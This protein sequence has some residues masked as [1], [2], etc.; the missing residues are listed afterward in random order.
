MTI[1]ILKAGLQTTIQ[2]QPRSGLR[3]M[4]VPSSGP[5]DALS[6]ALANRLVNNDLLAPALEVTLTG[7]SF[8]AEVPLLMAVTGALS[9]C[10]V[11]GQAVEQ[12]Q[13]VAVAAGA[14]VVVGAAEH[15]ARSYVAFA[16]GLI[17][18]VMLGSASTY[19]PAAFGGYEGRAL[20]R[21][22]VLKLAK[23]T[24]TTDA[25]CAPS[26]FR[27]P[28]PDA[29]TL[30][31]SRSCEI[32]LLSD[33]ERLF[34]TRFR[35]GGRCDRMG[36]VLEGQKFELCSEGRMASAAVFPGVVQCPENGEPFLL[37]VDAQTTGG[38]ARVAK[39]I[40]ADLHQLGQL[41][42]GDR[43]TLIER[44][45]ED[46]RQELLEKQVYWSEWLPGIARII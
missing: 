11:D 9:Q 42:P 36:M 41:R 4:G 27:L 17:A 1:R 26:Q 18:E 38:Y 22:D 24:D 15:G 25:L 13:S 12:H 2:A 31:A 10:S 19:L 5:A 3:H 20:R 32:R 21:G 23:R 35:I 16:G 8:V 33:P 43:L 34:D 29:W 45:D 40:R 46:A 14:E 28:M 44:S 6:M 30:R 7:V 37:S 39:I